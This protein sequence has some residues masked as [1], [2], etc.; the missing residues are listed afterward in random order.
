MNKGPKMNHYP[1]LDTVRTILKNQIVIF[2][3]PSMDAIRHNFRNTQLTD[4]EK[5][6]FEPK[7]D[8]LLPFWA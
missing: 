2:E 1:I 6:I 3:Y 4:L 8:P 7:N 5:V